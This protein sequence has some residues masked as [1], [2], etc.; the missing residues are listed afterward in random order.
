MNNKLLEDARA[1]GFDLYN[2]NLVVWIGST[3]I[4]IGL[5]LIKF[6][7]LQQPQWISVNESLPDKK[8]LAYYINEMGNKRTVCAKYT[9]KYSEEAGSDDD[10]IEYCDADDTYYYPE[11]WYEIID[12]WDDY[13][14]VTINYQV[15]HWMPLPSPP[16]NTED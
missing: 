6:A 13:N 4:D 9:K 2:G 1:A 7:E 5:E 3:P 11:G 14:S 8:C 15:T 12:N 10:W 16:I